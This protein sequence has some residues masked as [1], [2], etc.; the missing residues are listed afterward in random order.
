M[1]FCCLSVHICWSICL[2]VYISVCQSICLSFGLSVCLSVYQSVSSVCV[3]C[4]AGK[5]NVLVLPSRCPSAFL[6]ISWTDFYFL[7]KKQNTPII[8]GCQSKLLVSNKKLRLKLIKIYTKWNEYV[9]LWMCH[10]LFLFVS[11]MEFSKHCGWVFKTSGIWCCIVGQA[12]SEFWRI[13]VPSSSRVSHSSG[14]LTLEK[15]S[16]T[17][18]QIMRN[19]LLNS[20]TSLKTWM[21]NHFL[22]CL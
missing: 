15:G 11:H 13:V 1:S 7:N 3:H 10:W 14:L 2:S 19:H 21:F 16:T 18:L 5:Q 22:L 4:W 12:V 6:R 8:F 17:A 9:N 20:V